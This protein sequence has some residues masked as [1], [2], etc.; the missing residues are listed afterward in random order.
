MRASDLVVPREA[1]EPGVLGR[2]GA[3]LTPRRAGTQGA[4]Y[5]LFVLTLVAFSIWAP[6]FATTSSLSNIA[7]DAAPTV[8]VAVGMTFVIIAAEIDLSVAST[9][10]LSGL[11]GAVLLGEPGVPWPLAVLAA[12][13]IGAGVG[14]INGLLVGYLGVPSFLIT[15]GTLQ[16]V[17]AIA[18]MATATL[19][20]PITSS[21]FLDVF[22]PGSF[23]S[24][25]LTVWWALC[26]VLVGGYVLHA[27]KFGRW[28]YAVGDSR[29]AARYAG[30]SKPRVLIGVFVIAG[31]LAGLTGVL[32]AGRTTSGDP[33]A[34]TDMELTAIAAVI[35]G[36]TD[37]F[38]GS[39]LIIG[40]VVGS[41]FLTAIQIGLILLG[42]SGQLQT[43]V[44][45]VIIVCVVTMN[46]LAKGTRKA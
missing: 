37:L 24:V 6:S 40:T 30:I 46:A 18:L 7:R 15:L 22:G 20:Q 31:V 1:R 21:G 34:G 9:I 13:A 23:L 11:V 41:L 14:L 27:T 26:V 2:V 39:G 43:L 8:V 12:L 5:L 3:S 38:G 36:G 32:L 45:G 17:G 44:T 10:S 28:V 16:A 4:V 29:N 25:P 19:S 42:A 33:T 35:L